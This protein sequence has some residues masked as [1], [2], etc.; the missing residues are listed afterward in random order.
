MFLRLV[1]QKARKK[2]FTDNG[3]R[4]LS[5]RRRR[6]FSFKNLAVLSPTNAFEG[7][8]HSAIDSG[9]ILRYTVKKG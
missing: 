4:L 9:R 5:A 1:L 7:E 8:M 2:T 3:R 6:F